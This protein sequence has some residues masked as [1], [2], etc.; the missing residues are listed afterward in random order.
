MTAAVSASDSGIVHEYQ[1]VQPTFA[2]STARPRTLPVDPRL[3][4]GAFGE[5]I[6]GPHKPTLDEMGPHASLSVPAGGPAPKR[7]VKTIDVPEDNEPKTRRGRTR[8]T[9]R[10]G[11]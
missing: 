5:N 8:K 10:A 11:A 7:P 2:Q 9:G 3:K 1:P 6:K 4:A